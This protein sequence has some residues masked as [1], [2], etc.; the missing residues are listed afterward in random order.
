MLP[1]LA[2]RRLDGVFSALADPTRRAILARL[3]EGP[4]FEAARVA[5]VWGAAL[6]TSGDKGVGISLLESGEPEPL[7]ALSAEPAIASTDA[8][9]ETW[10]ADWPGLGNDDAAE[11]RISAAIDQARNHMLEVL[12]SLD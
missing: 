5:V 7:G 12:A 9:F 10:Q 8:L 6:A 3:T 4:A 2:D 11:Q 1:T